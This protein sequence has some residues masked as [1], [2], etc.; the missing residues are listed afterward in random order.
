MNKKTVNMERRTEWV[1]CISVVLLSL[2]IYYSKSAFDTV[3]FIG[4]HHASG[5]VD[6]GHY[7]IPMAE[8]LFSK[9]TTEWLVWIGTVPLQLFNLLILAYVLFTGRGC[10]LALCLFAVNW[11]HWL[12]YHFTVLPFPDGMFWGFPPGAFSFVPDSNQLTPDFWFSGH[13]A[14]V[15]LIL[16]A[17]FETRYLWFKITMLLVMVAE[18]LLLL[19]TRGHYS[20]D[21]IGAIFVSYSVYKFSYT[22]EP[23]AKRVIKKIVQIIS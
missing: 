1:K 20:I 16:L 18:I 3:T 11:M 12:F 19:S 6:V 10:R 14:Q 13:T 23:Y 2:A 5:I 4:Y 8:K 15:M 9:S 21:I 22:L 17:A 7:Y